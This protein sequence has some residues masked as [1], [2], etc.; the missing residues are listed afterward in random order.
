MKVIRERGESVLVRCDCGCEF[1]ANPC[2]YDG[3]AVVR[4]VLVPQ[5][6]ECGKIDKD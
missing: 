3:I 4:G 6:P 2:T 5:C 1:W